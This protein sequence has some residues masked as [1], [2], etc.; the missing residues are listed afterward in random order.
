MPETSLVRAAD[1]PIKRHVQN[2]IACQRRGCARCADCEASRAYLVRVQMD[3]VDRQNARRA[4][5]EER[6]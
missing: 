1:R 4:S 2:V 5:M 3:A 6:W